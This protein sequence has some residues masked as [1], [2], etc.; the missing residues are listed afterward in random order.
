MT[1]DEFIY[2]CDYAGLLPSKFDEQTWTQ[3][4]AKFV[5]I[6][7]DCADLMSETAKFPGSKSDVNT[8][9]KKYKE[10]LR[11]SDS[12]DSLA[13]SIDANKFVAMS[14]DK[15]RKEFKAYL[16]FCEKTFFPAYIFDLNPRVRDFLA[17]NFMFTYANDGKR[18]V[19]MRNLDAPGT[20]WREAASSENAFLQLQGSMR[21]KLTGL[22]STTNECSTVS[23]ISIQDGQPEVQD[24]I[25]YYK[26]YE[27]Y[28]QSIMKGVSGTPA[29][30]D[31]FKTKLHEYIENLK[32]SFENKKSKSELS[33]GLQKIPEMLH[34]MDVAMD[35]YGFIY[36]EQIELPAFTN[37]PNEPA[38]MY[39]DLNNIVEGPTPDFDGFM[40]SVVPACRE[41]LMAGI[42]ATFFAQSHL[43]QYIWIESR[44]GDGKSSLFNAMAEYAGKNLSC[45][46]GQ[47]LN[48]EFGLENAV[49]KRMVILSDVK[50]G[51]SVKSQLIHNLTGHD[52]ISINRKNKPI[53]SAR[54]DP[55]LWI[56]ANNPPDVNFA[57]RNEARRC[58]YIKMQEPPI[59]IKRKFY[60]TDDKG[61]LI[62]DAS[63]KPINNGYDLKGNLIKEMPHILYKC[64]EVFK[65][66]CPPPYSVIKQTTE[67]SALTLENCVDLDANEWSTY[68]E[69]TFDFRN[70]TAKLKITEIQ[71][72]IRETRLNHGE[73]SA[74]SN[75][76][77][78]DIIQLLV[79]GYKC[80]KKK[81][82]GIRYLEGISIANTSVISWAKSA[83]LQCTA[84][85]TEMLQNLY[86]D[87]KQWCHECGAYAK[88]RDIWLNGL[89]N[90]F[91]NLITAVDNKNEL[92]NLEYCPAFNTFTP[93][94][95]VV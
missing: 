11:T 78:G 15:K 94:S 63:G 20:I 5:G 35:E 16:N 33:R 10:A 76:Q 25:P 81:V 70:P 69:E 88:S 2:L 87:Y 61:N 93:V 45:S 65:R 46:L 13:V 7:V 19:Y 62:L 72:A 86:D 23:V 6:G 58:L 43:N 14:D 12:T 66:V 84:A 82:K 17:K 67:Q 80:S 50:T 1:V 91:P 74:I 59:E 54:L 60:F 37:D 18:I 41:S 85:P 24:G 21:K 77:K 73:R 34:N 27:Y 3:S 83:N 26:L 56:A 57:N 29:N 40:E 31:Y 44:G 28:E 92:I 38:F 79:N 71:E 22:L 48:T 64:R 51:L 55:I 42:F 36:K 95:K 68:I 4:I 75:Y 47:T 30:V 9:L 8:T 90:V 89:R 39:F 49:G 52:I 32:R 53:I